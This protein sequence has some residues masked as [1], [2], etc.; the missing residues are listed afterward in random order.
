MNIQISGASVILPEGTRVCDVYISDGIISGIGEM[1]EGFSAHQTIDAAGKLLSPGLVN[2][3]TH[4]YM[5]VF[6]NCADDLSFSD[7]LFGKISPMEDMLSVE[8]FYWGSMLAN[9]EMISTGTTTFLDMHMCPH[10]SARAAADSGIRAVLSRGLVGG[11]NDIEGGERRIREAFEEIDEWRSHPRLSFMLAP[12]APYTCDESYQRRIADLAAEHGLGIHTHLSESLGEIESIRE[13]YGCTP[14]ELAHRTGLLGE[15]T[16]AA[17]CVHL[18][19]SD[20]ELLAS[21]RTSVAHNPTSN[22]KLAN[23]IAPVPKLM[24]AGV[25]VALGTDGCAS[26]NAL[27]M[28]SEL[29]LAALLHKGVSGNPTLVSAQDAF[30]MATR[31]GAVALGLGGVVGEIRT[32]LA[33]DLVIFDLHRANMQP[34][35]SHIASL[36]YSANGSEAETVIIGGEIVMQNREIK[37]IDADRVYYEVE[38]ICERIGTRS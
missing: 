25:H 4:G 28:I 9:L 3:H 8:D 32:G 36:A 38:K 16:V 18:T 14:I 12:H 7:W 6:R 31:N 1:P 35:N 24:D 22:L 20:I 30:L 2:A 15:K 21:S 17:H 29:S 11:A 27:N 19:P 5:T 33:A 37:T 23:G 34:V 10:L 26:N 13:S